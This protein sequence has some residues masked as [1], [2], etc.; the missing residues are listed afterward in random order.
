M[1]KELMFSSVNQAWETRW[2]T[3]YQ[4]EALLG[5]DYNLDPACEIET[6]KCEN[7]LTPKQDIFTIKNPLDYFNKE[8]ELQIWMN[9]P[10]GREQKKFVEHVADW[11]EY[12]NIQSDI[13]IPARTGTQLYHDIIL[14]RASAIYFI[15]G[16]LVFGDD[17]YWEW[18]WEQEFLDDGKDGKKKNTLYKKYGRRDAAPFDSMI[19]SFGG[20]EEF[21]YG[22][23]VLEK[24]DYKNYK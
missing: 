20:T 14:P 15:K 19:V 8:E 7:Y 3:F 23:L 1:N 2:N 6:S 16:R 22:S 4:I 10:Y 18:L 12:D 17:V 9:P 5:R 21:K 11:C 24:E 13:L